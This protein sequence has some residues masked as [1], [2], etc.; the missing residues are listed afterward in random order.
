MNRKFWLVGIL[1]ISLLALAERHRDTPMLGRTH[2]Q[3]AS[4]TTLGKE[5][6]VFVARL[7]RQREAEEL[8]VGDNEPYSGQLQGD[9]LWRHGTSRGLPHAL[10]EIRNDLIADVEGQRAWAAGGGRCV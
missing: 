4:P 8:V 1:L 9:C 10:I 6:A 7:A 2:G 3:P 5:M